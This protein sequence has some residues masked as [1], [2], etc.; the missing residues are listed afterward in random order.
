MNKIKIFETELD[1][2]C[3]LER[4]PVFDDRGY[5]ERIFCDDI[6]NHFF[7]NKPIRQVNRSYSKKKGTLRG[8]HFQRSPYSDF[9]HISCLKGKVLDVLIDLRK[10][11]NFLKSI[12]IELSENKFNSIIVPSGVAHG[13]QTLVDDCELL[14][15]HNEFYKPNYEMGLNPL[16]KSLNIDWPIEISEISKRDKNHPLISKDII[17]EL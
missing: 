15:I 14:Y 2:V 9:K 13:F 4:N 7:D 3:Y 12:K 17:D 6:L 11:K 5:F 1:D 16:D 10:G 8:M